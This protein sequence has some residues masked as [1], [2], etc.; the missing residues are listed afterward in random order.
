MIELLVLIIVFI[1]IPA[2]IK[3]QFIICTPVKLLSYYLLSYF[4]GDFF[5]TDPARFFEL[6][7]NLSTYKRRALR[8][9]GLTTYFLML[10]AVWDADYITVNE[11]CNDLD[12]NEEA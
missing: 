3:N 2:M 8:E 9:Q 12:Y 7:N 6:K 5:K 4:I 11:L 1:F 10:R